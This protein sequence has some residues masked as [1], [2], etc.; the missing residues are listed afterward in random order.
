MY[1][2]PFESGEYFG[3]NLL[4]YFYTQWQCAGLFGVLCEQTG[5][6]KRRGR[7]KTL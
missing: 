2:K 1:I 5:I 3:E 6:A 4:G 7:G